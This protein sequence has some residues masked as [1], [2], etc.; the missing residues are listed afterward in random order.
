[1]QTAIKAHNECALPQKKKPNISL[2]IVR[3]VS[4][5]QPVT[6]EV[7]CLVASLPRGTTTETEWS[8]QKPKLTPSTSQMMVK[9]A[10]HW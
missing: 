1:M 2:I 7:C 5:T 4:D 8:E 3:A 10:S 6:K 9:Y